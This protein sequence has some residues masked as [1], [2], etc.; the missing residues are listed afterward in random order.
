MSHNDHFELRRRLSSLRVE[1]PDE[2]FEARLLARLRQ[3][4]RSSLRRGRPRRLLHLVAAGV[5]FTATA[6]AAAVYVGVRSMD[7]EASRPAAT[8]LPL[9]R[10]E[11]ASARSPLRAPGR[12]AEDS[13]LNEDPSVQ[14]TPTLPPPESAFEPRSES[15]LSGRPERRAP[16][17]DA[18]SLERS[19]EAPPTGDGQGPA[20]TIG[21]NPGATSTRDVGATPRTDDGTDALGAAVASGERP[22]LERLSI[23]TA[24]PSAGSASAARPPPSEPREGAVE[25]PS[26]ARAGA[27]RDPRAGAIRDPSAIHREG[28]GTVPARPGAAGRE[29]ALE[30]A[31]E[32]RE[33]APRRGAGRGR[34]P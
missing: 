25:R 13:E 19:R 12:P 2:A 9:P 11:T 30:R 24:R 33:A 17:L 34:A 32:A 18:P 14:A 26:A 27:G 5:S 28:A 3:E 6:A 20:S 21:P 15:P 16:T 8:A 7:G 10:A 22:P 31:A 4:S 29:R 1:T 23:R